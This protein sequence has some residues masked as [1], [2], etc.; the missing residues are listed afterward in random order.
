MII[1]RLAIPSTHGFA[2]MAR[3]MAI[4]AFNMYDENGKG[5]YS[6]RRWGSTTQ[7]C[8]GWG[9]DAGASTYIYIPGHTAEDMSR[10]CLYRGRDLRYSMRTQHR[11]WNGDMHPRAVLRP[12]AHLS[13]VLQTSRTSPK[14]CPRLSVWEPDILEKSRLIKCI[15]IPSTAPHII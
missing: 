15:P 12:R 9:R 4:W 5:V 3:R 13:F 11:Y 6:L 7:F 14:R 1:R 8:A 2:G 10:S